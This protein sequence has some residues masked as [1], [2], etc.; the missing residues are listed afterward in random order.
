M[1]QVQARILKDDEWV[2]ID[3]KDLKPNDRFQLIN[4][5]GTYHTDGYGKTDWIAT[6][7]PYINDDEIYEIKTLI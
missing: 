7:N 3:F 2:N 6:S 4:P 1:E 5:D